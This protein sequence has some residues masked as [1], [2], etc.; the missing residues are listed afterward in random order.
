MRQKIIN[1]LKSHNI[2]CDEGM[3]YTDSL[4]KLFDLNGKWIPTKK[5][6]V[7]Y[8]EELKGK[9]A[10]NLSEDVVDLLYFFEKE[11][12]DGKNIN[13][14][15]SRNIFVS[16]T[17]DRLLN[18]WNIHHLHLNKDEATSDSEMRSNR[19]DTYLLFLI[20]AENVYFLDCVP[21]LKG[22]EFADLSFIEIIFN[23]KW[24]VAVPLIKLNN[25]VSLEV[26]IRNKE[27]IYTLWKNNVN[28][29]AYRFGD[30][31]YSIGQ[32]ISCLGNRLSDTLLKCDLEKIL[33]K[34]SQDPTLSLI[35]VSIMENDC[36]LRILVKH[37][38]VD[39][40]IAITNETG[41]NCF[42]L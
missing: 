4:I 19:S 6:N 10:N 14:H 20:D 36:I 3:T 22:D 15:L 9:M 39:K 25:I 11:F 34:L 38:G 17:Y 32:R 24:F 33:F 2:R 27:E 29:A 30:E 21:H 13:C 41:V 31:F 28:I 18:H 23:N 7:V 16:E 5:R 1:F 26:D 8:S 37:N 35:D 42:D 12:T 40:C